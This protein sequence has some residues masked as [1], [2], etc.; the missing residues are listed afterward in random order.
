ME[1]KGDALRGAGDGS[2][3]GA[4]PI[5]RDDVD[6][7]AVLDIDSAELEMLEKGED[8]GADGSLPGATC[9]ERNEVEKEAVLKT[10]SEGGFQSFLLV[11]II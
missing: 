3:P 11:E 1:E 5:E 6:R 7:A 2:L 10:D 8:S 4:I 9:F